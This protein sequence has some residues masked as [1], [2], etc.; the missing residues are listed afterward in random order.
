M[1]KEDLASVDNLEVEALS[2]EE[3]DS[4]AGGSAA[5]GATEVA[6]CTCCIAG[7]GDTIIHT[8]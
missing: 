4:V 1:S 6:S 8:T 7:G 2:D 5:A 3:L